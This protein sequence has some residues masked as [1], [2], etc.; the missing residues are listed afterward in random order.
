MGE[1]VKGGKNTSALLEYLKGMIDKAIRN[2]AFS[3]LFVLHIKKQVNLF[4][5]VFTQYAAD[6]DRLCGHAVPA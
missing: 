3:E 5:Y 1:T 6:C 4:F 2:Q